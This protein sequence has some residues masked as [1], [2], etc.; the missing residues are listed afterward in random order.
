[1]PEA[2]Q[3]HPSVD[4][5]LTAAAAGFAGGT[6][7]CKCASNPVKVAIRG[8]IAYDH[9]CGCTKCWKPE[10]AMFSVVAVVPRDNLSVVENGN[11]LAVVDPSA[12][13]QRYACRDCGVHMYGRI[14]NKD[15]PFFGFD[16]IHPER[17]QERGWAPPDFAAFVSSVI[18]SG[19]KPE[20]M[21]EVRTRLKE[22]GLEPYDCL[23]PPLMDA[24]ATHTAKA[25]GV[26]AN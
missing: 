26:L 3:I 8:Q 25:K 11:K 6:L 19:V 16:F 4:H 5:G 13:I 23:S 24:I 7:L 22:L 2:V 21:G 20:R 10:G 17:F 9:V 18:E 1:M 15:H 12:A 14:E